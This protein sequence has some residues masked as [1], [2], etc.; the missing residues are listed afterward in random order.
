MVFLHDGTEIVLQTYLAVDGR[1]PVPSSPIEGVVTVQ[2]GVVHWPSAAGACAIL[3][4]GI[5]ASAISELAIRAVAQPYAFD[6]AVDTA[7]AG[8]AR[9]AAV[10]G[11]GASATSN[12][13][14]PTISSIR[15]GLQAGSAAN[16]S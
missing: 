1:I 5:D 11:A 3:G 14:R 10:L 7:G 12:V 4:D 8:R 6:G 13:F 15:R 2:N 9:P 16:Q